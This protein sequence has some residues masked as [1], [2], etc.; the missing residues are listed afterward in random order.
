MRLRCTTKA[1]KCSV[2]WAAME[3]AAQP[4]GVFRAPPA[5]PGLPAQSQIHYMA[6]SCRRVKKK[7]RLPQHDAVGRA[8]GNSAKQSNGACLLG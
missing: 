6:R 4:A 2:Q 5:S 3:R 8:G 7:G 1:L